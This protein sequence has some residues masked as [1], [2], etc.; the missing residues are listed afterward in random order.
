MQ[1][2]SGVF[3]FDTSLFGVDE[4]ER[5]KEEMVILRKELKDSRANNE[6][7]EK[8]LE[9]LKANNEELER[10]VSDSSANNN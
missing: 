1:I 6:E 8:A 5:L 4:P 7:L 2:F 10:E 3:D 9:Y